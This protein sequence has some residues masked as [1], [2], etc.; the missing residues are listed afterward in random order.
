MHLHQDLPVLIQ[1]FQMLHQPEAAV[2]A[3][4]IPLEQIAE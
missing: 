2:A 4:I 3:Q 1:F